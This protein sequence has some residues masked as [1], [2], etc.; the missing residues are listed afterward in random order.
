ML[1]CDL[2]GNSMRSS[3]VSLG[4]FTGSL[5]MNRDFTNNLLQILMEVTRDGVIKHGWEIPE[6]NE[7]SLMDKSSNRKHQETIFD[8]TGG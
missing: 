8:D 6:L 4:N 7:A 1:L 2:S 3:W 5:V